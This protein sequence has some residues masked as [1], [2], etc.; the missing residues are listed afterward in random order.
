MRGE[1]GQPLIGEAKRLDAA[2]GTGLVRQAAGGD[3]AFGVH[4]AFEFAQEPGVELA[5]IVYVLDGEAGAQCLRRHQQPI[6]TRRRQRGA[7]GVGAAVAGWLDL[8]E[9]GQAGLHASQPLLQRLGEAAPDRH[10]LADGFHRCGQQRRR[11]GKFLECETR[12]LHHDVI[13]GG[14]EACRRDTGDVVGEFVQRVADGELCRDLGDREAGGLRRERRRPR[15]ARVH[16]DDDHAA[17]GGVHR[18]LHV[19]APGIDADRAQ[20]GDRCVAHP[21]VL[22]VGQRQ[23][24][25]DGDAVAGVDAHRIDVLDRT[26]DDAVVRMIADDLH[27]EFLPAQHGFFDQH[28]RGG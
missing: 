7:E 18:E 3:V 25:G 2:Q 22:F 17:V 1:F 8:V 21:L 24:R 10:R 13:D 27:L 14:F 26:H 20:A 5:G 9:T 19:G 4:D 15:N 16:L 6:R 12:D 23:R 28:F 11:A